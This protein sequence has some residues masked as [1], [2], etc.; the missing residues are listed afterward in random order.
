[1]NMNN[2]SEST[3]LLLGQEFLTWLWY[4]SDTASG[5]FTD[6]SGMFFTVSME[7]HIVVEGG[8]GEARETASVSGSLSPLR[9]ARFG[10]CMGKKVS[11]ALLR[12]EKDEFVFQCSIRAVDFSLQSLRTPKLDKTINDDDDLESLLLE[13]FYLME[14]CINLLQELYTRFLKLR[15]SPEWINEINAMRHWMACT[16]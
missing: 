16:E 4:Q 13:K 14:M 10:L 2:P 12:I 9:E 11:R 8:Q 7:Q 1:M 15:L 6:K 5:T 3:D